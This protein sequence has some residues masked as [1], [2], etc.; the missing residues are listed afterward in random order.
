MLIGPVVVL[1]LL[2]LAAISCVLG[3]N[4]KKGDWEDE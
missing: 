4:K 1:L 3:G 2:G